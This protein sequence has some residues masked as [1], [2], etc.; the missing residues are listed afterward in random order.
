M[1]GISRFSKDIKKPMKT[2]TQVQKE[3][4]FSRTDHIE[5]EKER[6]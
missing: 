3:T 2:G 6:R 1:V 4:N 5:M